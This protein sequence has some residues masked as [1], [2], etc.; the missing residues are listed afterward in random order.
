MNNKDSDR[1]KDIICG[2][3]GTTTA[4]IKKQIDK[5]VEDLEGISRATGACS[6]CGACDTDILA[7]I[8]EY[9]SSVSRNAA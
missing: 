8:A 9:I 2:C 5:G 1:K 6:G 7:L 4:Q 3:S